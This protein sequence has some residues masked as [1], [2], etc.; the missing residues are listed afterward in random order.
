[1]TADRCSQCD[2]PLGVDLDGVPVLALPHSLNDCVVELRWQREHLRRALAAA[3]ADRERLSV[4]L[5]VQ[6]S[7]S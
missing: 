7:R 4:A 2:T 6:T 3:E 5:A 1:M